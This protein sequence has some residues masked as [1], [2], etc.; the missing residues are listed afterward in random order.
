MK[1]SKHGFASRVV[2]LFVLTIILFGNGSI[3]LAASSWPEKG[4]EFHLVAGYNPGG[5]TDA[6]CRVCAP[7]IEKYLGIPVVVQN[8]P[9]SGGLVGTNSVFAGKNDG[10]TAI[11]TAT[12]DGIWSYTSLSPTSVPWKLSDWKG[13]G[14]YANMG[15]MGLVSLKTSPWKDFADLIE[16]ARKRPEKDITLASLGPGR[17][18][19]LWVI[20]I[21]RTFGVKFNWVFYDG[22]GSIQ[23]DLIT[24][25]VDVAIIGVARKDFI[26]H[27]QFRVL[28]GF[29]SE[30]PDGCAYKDVFPTMRDFETRLGYKMEDLPALSIKPILSFIVKADIPDEAYNAISAA[31][32]KMCE[33]TAWQADIK[34]LSWPT[35]IPPEE[36][37]PIF[38]SIDATIASYKDLHKQY[39]TR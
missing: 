24:G 16:D 30:Y 23:T 11:Y 26:D 20:E 18:D 6:I 19:D 17:L 32:K 1:S 14:I 37:N 28:A 3:S 13:T 7:Y 5:A 29:V 8:I 25:D 35:Y 27:P 34:A 2:F 9:G 15:T 12:T 36:Q 31:V 38:K 39:V 33:D 21:E 10:Y 22:S 4:R